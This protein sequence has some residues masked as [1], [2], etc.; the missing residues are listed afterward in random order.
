M[1]QNEMAGNCAMPERVGSNEW[2]GVRFVISQ[3][4]NASRDDFLKQLHSSSE[5]RP[6]LRL[7]LFGEAPL[8]YE[9]GKVEDVFW[10]DHWVVK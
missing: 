3:G 8:L 6:I 1:I 2:L 7:D 9:F 5:R 10:K 4:R